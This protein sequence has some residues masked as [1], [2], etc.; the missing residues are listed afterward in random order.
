[1][2]SKAR[3]P[4]ARHLVGLPRTTM[5][6]DT[7]DAWQDWTEL[8]FEEEPVVEE[9]RIFE[10]SLLSLSNKSDSEALGRLREMI[11]EAHTIDGLM[12]RDAISWNEVRLGKLA[13]KACIDVFGLEHLESLKCMDGLAKELSKQ[14]E[15]DNAISL[16]S[17]ILKIRTRNYGSLHPETLFTKN[18][19]ARIYKDQGNLESA[20][21]LVKE[22]VEAWQARDTVLPYQTL[23]YMRTGEELAITLRLCGYQNLSLATH[24]DVV[25]AMTDKF[26]GDCVLWCRKRYSKLLKQ[27]GYKK[28]A[29]KEAQDVVLSREWQD[30]PT[31]TKLAL[32]MADSGNFG[33]AEELQR[34][35][36]EVET[37]TRSPSHYSVL[38]AKEGLAKILKARGDLATAEKLLREC[39]G[40]I[41]E[42]EMQDSLEKA[43]RTESLVDVLEASGK[44]KD[45]ED[46]QEELVEANLRNAGPEHP[47]TLR[48]KMILACR[49]RVCG[50]KRAIQL[51]REV[52]T[53]RNDKLG[54]DHF[55]TIASKARLVTVLQFAGQHNKAL[56]LH[57]EVVESRNRTL[58][59][60]DPK[61]IGAAAMDY[62]KS[63]EES[64]K[65]WRK[66]VETLTELN[67]REHAQTLRAQMDWAK[68][69]E[70]LGNYDAAEAITTS[71]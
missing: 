42:A 33:Y 34:E 53:I 63:Q 3:I 68:S 22:L 5:A 25:Q 4:N 9:K 24:S 17:R 2:A 58:G 46:L 6:Y 54:A 18:A 48:S 40:D 51:L 49:A 11:K 60:E 41:Q 15:F 8:E 57:A 70:F 28:L 62:S 55:D 44:L 65:L 16:Q 20:D 45:A 23:E 14:G 38:A 37:Q 13:C 64:E 36:L 61:T 67:G 56:K 7:Y 47:S 39:L 69:L 19:L 32:M 1:M 59:P 26:G 71:V 10:R 31:M 27:S 50:T 35:V 30:L 52:V 66:L 43:W 12:E 21:N 29:E